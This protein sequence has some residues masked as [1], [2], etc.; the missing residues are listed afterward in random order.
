MEKKDY[1]S[2]F[3]NNFAAVYSRAIGL[4]ASDIFNLPASEEFIRESEAKIGF[5]LPDD[6]RVA[7]SCFDGQKLGRRTKETFQVYGITFF[8]PFYKWH[9]LAEAV[10]V[11]GMYVT[12]EDS[13]DH[14]NYAM[15]DSNGKFEGA[16]MR[17]GKGG[18]HEMLVPAECPP[19]FW[20][21][22]LDRRRFPLGVSGHFAINVDMNP[23][24]GGLS[25][26]LLESVISG[27]CTWHA[28][29]FGAYCDRFVELIDT[30][31]IFYG[32]LGWTDAATGASWS[33][34]FEYRGFEE[35]ARFKYKYG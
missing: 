19:A 1:D 17:L 3:W 22:L 14:V 12:I 28:P 33:R 9:N 20:P 26:Q 13:C 21:V 15:Y 8:Q 11:W 4:P 10:Q 32:P 29:G 27:G 6:V 2:E 25:G 35:I 23:R 5:R 18:D 31:E 7:Y 24:E 34:P 16:G 30:G